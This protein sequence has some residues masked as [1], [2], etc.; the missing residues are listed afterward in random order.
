MDS[1]QTL[2]LTGMLDLK[3]TKKQ[4]R[5]DIRQLERIVAALRVTGIFAEAE[6]K[7]ELEACLE[8]IQ[9]RVDHTKLSVKI[10]TKQLD[11][12]INRLLSGVSLKDI[13]ALDID[14]NKLAFKIKK[15]FA[16]LQVF[17]SR[18]PIPV[19]L[20]SR[21]NKLENNLD[22]YM[23]GNT[24]ISSSPSLLEE[25]EKVRGLINSATD[26]QSLNDAANALTLFCA[27]VKAAGIETVSSSG[28][29]KEIILHIKTM[30]DVLGLASMTVGNFFKSLKISRANDS[31]LTQI[32]GSPQLSKSS[33]AEIRS[34]ALNAADRYGQPAGDYLKNLQEMSQ[35]G[36]LDPEGIAS[37]SAALQS[38]GNMTVQLANKYIAATDKAFL[39]RGSVNALTAA[40]DGACN[41]SRRHGISMGDLAEA[42]SLVGSQAAGLGLD[43]DETTAALAAMLAVTQKNGSEAANA[44]NS[45]L[46]SLSQ[47]TGQLGT[48]GAALERYGEACADLSI[49]LSTIKSGVSSLKEPMGFIQKLSAAYTS[50]DASDKRRPNLL[51]AGGELDTEALKAFL[52]NYDMYEEMLKNYRDGVGS[53]DQEAAE[54]VSSWEGHLNS[55]QNKWDSFVSGLANKELTQGG[56]SFL[57]RL[58]Q[59]AE[60]LTD[61]VGEIPA[62]LTILNT[63]KFVKDKNYGITSLINRQTSPS[64]PLSTPSWRPSPGSW[65]S[66]CQK[67][68]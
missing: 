21:T 5:S 10:D 68:T 51:A 25:A 35:A 22:S 43:I 11:N 30:A 38:A 26:K 37:L 48:G 42:M 62:I 60:K 40:L 33:P 1:N 29:V 55:L 9:A 47:V 64:F 14:E 36:Y 53:L 15:V 67:M 18:N 19:N 39:M 23:S 41:I 6:T 56:I 12:E 58:I 27:T 52:E 65:M 59:S 44:F 8:Q 32:S 34:R 46:T 57:E 24:K 2:K 28:K 50:L 16:N 4:M 17:F 3:K 20:H 7:R 31:I 66:F 13:D 61:T 49:P 63:S 54:A 45:L